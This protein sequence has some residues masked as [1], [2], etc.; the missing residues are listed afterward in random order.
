MTDQWIRK[1][2]VLALVR[3]LPDIVGKPK[4]GRLANL[5]RRL[6]VECDRELGKLPAAGASDEMRCR[7]LIDGW[8]QLAGW[9][10][11]K[12]HVI[13]YVNFLLDALEREGRF[14]G[15]IAVLELVTDYFERVGDAPAATF[16]SGALAAEK[17]ARSGLDRGANA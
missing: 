17:W 11:R 7:K 9:G 5:Y 6:K 16:W 8:Q 12:L 15:V 14:P 4:P 3:C 10:T 1:M 13:S 2:A